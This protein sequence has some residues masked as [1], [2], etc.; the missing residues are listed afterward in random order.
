MTAGR[1]L[2]VR[3]ENNNGGSVDCIAV[4]GGVAISAEAY[5]LPPPTLKLFLALCVADPHGAEIDGGNSVD[6]DIEIEGAIV[7]PDALVHQLAQLVRRALQCS[8]KFE[9]GGRNP[10]SEPVQDGVIDR[11]WKRESFLDF[12]DR[13]NLA[14][15]W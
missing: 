9:V 5:T 11:C 15:S 14:I 10:A 1:A 6:Q 2:R 7:Q 12:I 4:W 3:I 13:G 8:V